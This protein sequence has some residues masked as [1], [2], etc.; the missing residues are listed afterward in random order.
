MT[1]GSRE[2]PV[3]YATS[4]NLKEGGTVDTWLGDEQANRLT[5]GRCLV[6]LKKDTKR[7][8]SVGSIEREVYVLDDQGIRPGSVKYR[9]NVGAFYERL[10]EN[11]KGKESC[12]VYVHG[13]N[14]TFGTALSDGSRLTD[15]L[16]DHSLVF[17]YSW[18]SAGKAAAYKH[19]YA[20]IPHAAKH[21]AEL[22]QELR[23]NVDLPIDLVAHSM[24]AEV[25]MRA[26][27]DLAVHDEP[28]TPAGASCA[29]IRRVALAA[30]D[31]DADEFVEKY[32]KPS[33][34]LTEKVNVYVHGRD[35]ALRLSEK[36]QHRGRARLGQGVVLGD[37]FDTVDVT[38]VD[39]R[40]LI[41]HGYLF[42]NQTVAQDLFQYVIFGDPPERRGAKKEK[43]GEF[44]FYYLPMRSG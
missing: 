38:Q 23:G 6:D 8:A 32:V 12:V 1:E 27:R 34:A 44:F 25:A 14:S 4:R 9:R 19:D 17:V 31:I 37:E 36:T 20:G 43:V 24:G 10:A 11:L 28:T 13:F 35:L 39:R 5:R 40:D 18:P 30:P 7:V 3:F 42:K 16:N 2:I 21:L 33:M 41:K 29:W 22:L 15:N 26:L